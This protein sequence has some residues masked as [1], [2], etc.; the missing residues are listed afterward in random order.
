MNN[1][2]ETLTHKSRRLIYNFISNNPGIAFENIKRFFD[3]NKSTLNYHLKYIERN[4]KVTSKLEDGQRCYYCA[5]KVSHKI[6]PLQTRTPTNL[7]Q[8]QERLLTLIQQKPGVSNKELITQTKIN[9]K[10]LSYNI[11]KLRDQKLI[12]AVKNDGVLGYEFITKEKLQREMATRLISKLLAEEID[13]E[14]YHRIKD[15]L[16]TVDLNELMQ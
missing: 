3:M 2:G 11:K 9:R 10:N 6:L 5:Y 12:W 4:N 15:K 14:A 8:I 1:N 13:E 16:E 7:T